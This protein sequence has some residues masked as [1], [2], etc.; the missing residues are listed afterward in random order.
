MIE[1]L[2]NSMIENFD[3]EFQ[4]LFTEMTEI[5]FEYV[6]NNSNEVDAIYVIGLIESGYFY[7]SFYQINGILVKSHKVNTVSKMQYDIS[8]DRAFSLLKL[9]MELLEKTETLFVNDDREVPTMLKL[10]YY[11]QTGRFESDFSYDKTF[12]NSKTKTAQDVYEGWF[13]EIEKE[14]SIK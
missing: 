4:K 2:A 5:A 11:P 3:N 10:I 7:K 13:N 9:G 14:L 12:S 1:N 8:K 6:D